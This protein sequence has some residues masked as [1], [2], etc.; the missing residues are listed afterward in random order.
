MRINVNGGHTATAPGASGYLDEL[1][2]DRKVKDALIA[3][4]RDRGHTVSDST[5]PSNLGVNDDLYFQ[6]NSANG[7]GAELAVSIHFNAG[8]GRGTEVFYFGGDNSGLKYAQNVSYR[9][10]AALGLPNRG[11]KNGSHLYWVRNTYMTAILVEVC[12]VDTA[13]DADAYRRLGAYGVAKAIADAIVGYKEEEPVTWTWK[14]TKLS[15]SDRYETCK[16]VAD[17]FHKNATHELIVKGS[18]FPDGFVGMWRA[19]KDNARVTFDE[20][21][22]TYDGYT[23]A[24]P[25]RYATNEFFDKV[26]KELF[27]ANLGNT[28]FV[29]P[30]DGEKFADGNIIVGYSFDKSIPIIGYED[31]E[32]FKKQIS[33]FAQVIVI[34]DTVPKFQGETSRISGSTRMEVCAAAAEKFAS[35]WD[36]VVFVSGYSLPDAIAAAQIPGGYPVLF[37]D[38]GDVTINALK[39]HKSQIKSCYWVGAATNIDKATY[40]KLVGAMGI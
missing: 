26:Q 6:V 39:K 13:G 4:L 24:G 16:I 8:G 19:G 5:S 14:G 40:D 21:P 37:V 25:D 17:K 20:V 10:A 29:V 33:Q 36:N 23:A 28:C 2:E 7:S 18:N 32:R 1:T 12:F 31:S 3:I 35:S 9:L 27:G 38:G 15:G 30:I 34:G 22:I 11:A